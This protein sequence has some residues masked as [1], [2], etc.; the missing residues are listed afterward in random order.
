MT[1][2]DIRGLVLGAVAAV[3]AVD[4]TAVAATTTLA[5]LPTFNSFRMVEIVERLEG[6]LDVEV[7]G[8]D[9][10]P[11]NLNRVDALCALFAR[12]ASHVRG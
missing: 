9:L 1:A 12:T 8:T 11:D 10:V 6:Q 4:R 2:E 5:E 3:L 7:D